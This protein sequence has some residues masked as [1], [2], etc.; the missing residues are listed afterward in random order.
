MAL[1]GF[2]IKIGGGDLTLDECGGAIGADGEYSYFFTD[3]Y[4]YSL[5]CFKGTP[6]IP[7]SA[8]DETPDVTDTQCPSIYHAIRDMNNLLHVMNA[9]SETQN[10]DVETQ[11][12]QRKRTSS[13][14]DDDVSIDESIDSVDING[15]VIN[16][17]FVEKPIS[18]EDH[19]IHIYFPSTAG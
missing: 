19:R 9:G 16:K 11:R 6:M 8:T 2:R 10:V 7:V 14:D 12:Q 1:D 18:A 3:S 13:Q 4:P 5:R 17:P 15:T